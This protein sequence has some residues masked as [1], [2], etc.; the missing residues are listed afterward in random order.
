MIREAGQVSLGRY[1]PE[2]EENRW[3][4]READRMA[5]VAKAALNVRWLDRPSAWRGWNVIRLVGSYRRWVYVDLLE[6]TPLGSLPVPELR[7]WWRYVSV[8]DQIDPVE[9]D[10][11]DPP[12]LWR[13]GAVLYGEDEQDE[14][15]ASLARRR[16]WSFDR[17]LEREGIVR[18]PGVCTKLGLERAMRVLGLR[19]VKLGHVK[20]GIEPLMDDEEIA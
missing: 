2:T 5:A 19:F 1:E 4:K 8:I 16:A 7:S 17:E 20:H 13:G 10:M 3:M 15:V 18:L 11:R 12:L 6:W 9:F 14:K